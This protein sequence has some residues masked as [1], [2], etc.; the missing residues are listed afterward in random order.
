M[1]NTT[2]NFKG[3]EIDTNLSKF[4]KHMEMVV[5][6]ADE[7]VSL[8]KSWDNLALLSHFGN[9][10]TNINE[11]KNNFSDLTTKLLN[12]LSNEVLEKTIREMRFKAQISI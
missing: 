1:M 4:I 5:Q 6:Y 2:I 9:S 10:S 3:V 8:S 11:T 7:L 12:H